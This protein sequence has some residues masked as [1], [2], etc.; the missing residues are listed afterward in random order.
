MSTLKEI[1]KI[2]AETGKKTEIVELNFTGIKIE[3]FTP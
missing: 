2:I 1:E 3:R